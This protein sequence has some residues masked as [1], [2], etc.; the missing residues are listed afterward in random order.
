MT[1]WCTTFSTLRES[2]GLKEI[3]VM[4]SSSNFINRI[5]LNRLKFANLLSICIS[6]WRH[7]MFMSKHFWL[8]Y[9]LLWYLAEFHFCISKNNWTVSLFLKSNVTQTRRHNT[10]VGTIVI[11]GLIHSLNKHTVC[12]RACVC[13]HGNDESYQPGQQCSSLMS[14]LLAEYIFCFGHF[15]EFTDK[16]RNIKC[17]TLSFKIKIILSVCH[18]T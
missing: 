5:H 8:F 9:R 17:V 15:M 2:S 12:V 7:F 16:K 11:C 4:L 10:F 14:F 3:T 1:G 6:C 13:I 18:M